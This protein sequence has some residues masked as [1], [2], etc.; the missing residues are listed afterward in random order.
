M[1]HPKYKHVGSPMTRLI[2]ECAELQQALC[3]ANRFGWF[4]FNPDRPERTN[5]DDVQAEMDDVVEAME[6][7]QENMRQL[8]HEH[9]NGATT[10]DPN[11]QANG[12]GGSSP[13]PA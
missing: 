8:R 13:G 2:E 10:K 3:K 4:N 6:R 5:M 12:P 7:L 1:S 9:F 11:D